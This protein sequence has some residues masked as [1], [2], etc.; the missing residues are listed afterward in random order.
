MANWPSVTVVSTRM[1]DAGMDPGN[2]GNPVCVYCF[3]SD[4]RLFFP[5]AGVLLSNTECNVY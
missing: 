1:V 3:Y 2:P 5:L 4:S